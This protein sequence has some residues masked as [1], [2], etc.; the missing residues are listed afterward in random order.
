MNHLL[1]TIFHL[2]F[3]YRHNAHFKHVYL[4]DKYDALRDLV[5]FV[6]YKK[7][8]NTHEGVLILVKL[9]ASAKSNTPPCVFFTFFN[10]TN[11][12]KSSNASQ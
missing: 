2:A 4:H 3:C 6:Q 9:Q 5:P 7:L 11:G 8:K 1:Y 10:C 12:T